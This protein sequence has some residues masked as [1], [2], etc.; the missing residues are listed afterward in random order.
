MLIGYARVSTQDQN[1]D[2]QI[3]ALAEIGC[4]KIFTEKASG[5]S[6][7]RPELKKAMEYL[8]EKDSLVVWKLDRLARS[9]KQLI[10]TIETLNELN[11]GLKSLTESIDTNTSGGKFI[12][13]IFG[14]LAEFERSIIKDRTIA[15][16]AAAKARGKFPGRPLLLKKDDI[17]VAKTLLRDGKISVVDIAK[18]INVSPATLY[19]YFPG[20]RS[21]FIIN[22][23]N[24]N[25]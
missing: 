11:I 5:F 8:R 20:G 14:S 9:L 16:L 17:E 19:R 4:E 2:L 23:E 1:L 21:D 25:R 12:F 3:K 22:E 6:R 15:G 13:H 18:R 7:E 24:G 10:A